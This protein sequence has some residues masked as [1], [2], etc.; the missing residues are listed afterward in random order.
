MSNTPEGAP[1]QPPEKVVA[2]L[3]AH[4]RVL[5]WPSLALIVASGAVGY[6]A[7]R[8]DEVWEIVLLWSAA[9]AV[10]LLLFL[11]PLAAWL[12][13]RYTITTRRIVIRHGFFVRVRQELLHSRGYDVSVRRSWLQSMFRSGDVR[14]NSALEHPVVLKDVPKADQVQRALSELMDHGQNVVGFRRQQSESVSDETTV[15]GSR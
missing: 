10:L 5:F 4:A 3:R 14:I 15:W 7:G 13:R 11:L 9:A 2:R 12:S 6:F 8:L 1:A